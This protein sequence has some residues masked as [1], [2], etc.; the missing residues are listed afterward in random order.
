MG[1]RG[2]TSDAIFLP[3]PSPLLP[4]FSQNAAAAAA[5]AAL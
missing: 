4:P 2:G 5:N 3:S 1:W